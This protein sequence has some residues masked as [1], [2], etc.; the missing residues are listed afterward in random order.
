MES[1][2]VKVYAKIN[3]SLNVCGKTDNY[4]ALDTVMTSVNLADV[5]SVRKSQDCSFRVTFD[6][7]NMD[8]SNAFKAARLMSGR[9][10]CGGAD[11][12]V[13]RGIPSGG[14]LGG[15]S[16]DA[17][18]VMR[19]LNLLYGLKIDEGRLAEA[20]AEIGSD[21][22]YMLAGG[23]AR[24]VGTGG[25][26]KSFDGPD[27]RIILA[28]SGTVSTKECFE[29]FDRLKADGIAADNDALTARLV[30]GGF[31]AAAGFTGN[32]L[33]GAAA[34][35]NPSVEEIHGIMRSHGLDACMT[36][37]GAYV[38]GIGSDESMLAA[39][40]ALKERG[41]SSDIINIVKKGC[42]IV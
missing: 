17:A 18:G 3:L 27:G 20:A 36:G 6:G 15:S 29:T 2:S 41:Y 21:V 28:G 39:G 35:L 5:V 33:F 16:A 26:F 37:S 14:G 30:S 22:P 7:E 11:I 23:Y 31:N 19:A 42:E 10:G 25:D 12:C 40:T 9:F 38:F 32:A 13:R 1:V 34:A 4:H 8:S 24:L